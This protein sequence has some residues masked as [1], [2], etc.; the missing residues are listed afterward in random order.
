M[1]D[2]ITVAV[3]EAEGEVLDWMVATAMG[4][5]VTEDLGRYIVED[6]TICLG[7]IG[8]NY[9]PSTEQAQ[10]GPILDSQHISCVWLGNQWCAFHPQGRAHRIYAIGDN[11]FDVTR[12][13]ADGV[14]ATRLVAGMRAFAAVCLG[15]TFPVP[16]QLIN[17]NEEEPTQ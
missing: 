11:C 9:R 1:S 10:G 12:Q 3:A 15:A 4:L 14:G 7:H 5:S 8:K 13:D 2:M 16:A 17:R 6:G